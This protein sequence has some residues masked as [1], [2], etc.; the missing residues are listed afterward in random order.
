MER[1]EHERHVRTDRR[2]L[3]RGTRIARHDPVVGA[4]HSDIEERDHGEVEEQPGVVR[5]RRM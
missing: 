4:V 5:E 2:E 3:K 1:S